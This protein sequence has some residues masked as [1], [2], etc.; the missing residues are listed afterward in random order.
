MKIKIFYNTFIQIIGR[1]FTGLITY[2][3]TLI[4]VRQYGPVGFG[5]FVKIL[6][7]VSY[8]Y[9]MADFGLNAIALKDLSEKEKDEDKIFGNLFGMRV[10]LSLTL[11]FICL[12]LLVFIP[13][14][15]EQGF[16]IAAR[17]GIVFGSFTIITQAL[18]TTANVL[19]QKNLQYDKS[20]FVAAVGYMVTLLFCFLAA[21]SHF[22]IAF[23]SLGYVLGGATSFF[24][25]M[26]FLKKKFLFKTDFSYWKEMFLRSL[27]LGA[28]LILNIIYF[29][30][31]A[32][33][34]T[35]TRSTEEV[36]VYGLAYKFFEI[37]LVFPTFFMNSLYPVFL[38]RKKTISGDFQ[39]TL[40]QGG[41]FLILS[42]LLITITV[43]FLAPYLIGFTAGEK[44]FGFEGAILALRILALSLPF[45]FAS[46]F[47]MWLLVVNNDEK[48]MP[49]VYGISM[50]A[51]IILNLYLIPRFG[52]I[53]AAA[54]TFISEAAV[55]VLLA[56]VCKKYLFINRDE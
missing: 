2:L 31:D 53:A 46:S 17:L 28:T 44:S 6:T 54:T 51:N 1:F 36:G 24:L 40:F 12:V 55:V 29:K 19:F 48:K 8:F 15:T 16:T 13:Q 5:E 9:I 10:F 35:L 18:I 20:V 7:Y 50:M 43:Y 38:E 21:K 47:L 37:A 45:F 27:P 56:V 25:G 32:F 34:L 30:S 23:L 33:I 42:S 26:V 3:I 41:W 39:K 22:P 11:L 49:F 4:L 14:G 52:Y